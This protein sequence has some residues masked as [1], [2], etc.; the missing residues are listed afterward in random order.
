VVRHFLNPPNWF[1]SASIFCTSYAM[2]LLI[3]N[4][5]AHSG[6]PPP[7]ILIRACVLIVF[8]GLFDLMDGRVARLTNRYSEFGI[9]L[10]SIADVIGFGVAPAM[11]AFAW[12]LN[13]LGG[14]GVAVTFW[15]VLAT[16]FRLARFNVATTDTSWP[17][18]GHSQ[19]LTSTMSGGI[20]VSVV[21]LSNGYFVGRGDLSPT[22]VAAFVATLGLLMVSS[23]PYRTFKDLRHNIAA[24]RM[25]GVALGA[26]LVSAVVIDPSMW[27]GTGAVLYLAWGTIDGAV[28]AA[29][30]RARNGADAKA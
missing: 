30:H 9:Q 22:V 11:V 8:G 21:W 1:T 25:L 5:G 12:K 4:P 20:L 14:I 17:F 15:Y 23:V 13:E 24:R 2:M 28:I 16:A 27:F 6:G 7:D 19:G 18:A 10:D 26:C 3:A 29:R